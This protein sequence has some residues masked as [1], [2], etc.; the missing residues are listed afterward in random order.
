MHFSKT[1]LL[2]LSAVVAAQQSSGAA[3]PVRA[4]SPC[5]HINQ[6][7]KKKATYAKLS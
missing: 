4:H 6:P 3:E 5:T 2:A 7:T 1:L